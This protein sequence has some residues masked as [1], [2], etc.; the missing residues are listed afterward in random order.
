MSDEMM[1]IVGGIG[2]FFLYQYF[3]Q[4]TAASTAVAASVVSTVP[5][6]NV[7]GDEF[8]CSVGTKYYSNE[9]TNT[10]GAGYCA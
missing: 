5:I 2:A 6:A 9:G 3:Q 10:N 4:Q 8:S 1:L 7:S